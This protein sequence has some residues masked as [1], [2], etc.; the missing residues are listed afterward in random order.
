[1]KTKLFLVPLILVCLTAVG[2]HAQE[3]G[4]DPNVIAAEWQAVMTKA[5]DSAVVENGKVRSLKITLPNDRER[6]LTLEHA[7]DNR[8][9]TIVDEGRRIRVL[10]DEARRI[11]EVIFPNG[12]KARFAWAMAPNGYW[13]PSAIKVERA[14]LCRSGAL[15]EQDCRPVCERAAQATVI[16]IGVCAVSGPTLPCWTATAVAAAAT[17]QCYRCTNP[18]AEEPC[19]N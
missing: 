16:A 10:L 7:E 1:M 13:V 17:Y 3:G 12:K 5:M 18:E 11:S 2:S 15:V 19:Q 9:F 14:E 6:L 8:S 4:K